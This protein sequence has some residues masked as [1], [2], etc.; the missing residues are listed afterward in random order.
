MRPTPEPITVATLESPLGTLLAG[1]TPDA[2]VVL[3]FERPDDPE[4]QLADLTR[5]VGSPAVSGENEVTERVAAE[6]REYF[7][8][9]RREFTVLLELR[10]TPFQ[11]EVWESLRRIPYG[12]TRSYGQQAL[13]IGRPKAVRAVAQANGANRVSLIVPCH[14][15]IGADGSLTGYGAGVWRKEKL[16]E[17]ERRRT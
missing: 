15:V 6:L 2:L 5:M 9:Q 16:L 10:G 7:D 17:L 13:S 14:R 1:A 11:R 4:R 3:E 8:G 12:E